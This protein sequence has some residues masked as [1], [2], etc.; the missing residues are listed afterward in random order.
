MQTQTHQEIKQ[1]IVIFIRQKGPS[2]PVHIGREIGYN[3][4][5][6]SAFLSELLAEKKIRMSFLRVGGSPLYLIPGQEPH[7]ENF[8][9]HLNH[10]EKEAFEILKEEKFLIDSEQQPAI[11][12]ALRTIK[13]FAFPFKYQEKIIWRYFLISEEE[14][15]KKL[16]LTKGGKEENSDKKIRDEKNYSQPKGQGAGQKDSV[17][18]KEGMASN[19]KET[20]L[21][22]F[23]RERK[24]EK[25]TKKKKSPSKIS[26][27]FFNQVKQTLTA[28]NYELL[29]IINYNKNE[30]V[31]SVKKD[32]NQFLAIAYNKK[33]IS[34][35]DIS[36]AYRK[37]LEIKTPYIILS[38]GELTK[39]LKEFLAAAKNLSTIEKIQQ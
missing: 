25:K 24:P 37:A 19:S 3:T 12:V 32:D 16:A 8:S 10:K 29:D 1:K 7:L 2:L 22:I 34:E 9:D 26:D 11:R 31:I 38:K 20:Q 18:R 36:K 28:K 21:N 27:K 14:Y 5:Y 23:D 4:I 39:K 30:L 6:A 17:Q 35:S 13:D 33:R 15:D